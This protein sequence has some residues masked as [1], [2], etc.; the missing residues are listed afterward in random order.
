MRDPE[1]E[2]TL[3][4]S[5]DIVGHSRV[6]SPAVQSSRVAGINAVVRAFLEKAGGLAY[7]T[8]GGDG[9]HV[10]MPEHMLAQATELAFD[11]RR[12][13]VLN[14][15]PLRI[16]V[17]L[18][19]VSSIPGADGRVQPV[20]QG[21]NE[22]G[23]ILEAGSERGV[24]ASAEFRELAERQ[25]LE[26]RFHDARALNPKHKGEHVL[27]LMSSLDW[28]S[29][30]PA[31][32]DEEKRLQLSRSPSVWERLY[33]IKKLAQIDTGRPSVVSGLRS[34]R[35]ADFSLRET[36]PDADST[37]ANPFLGYL[38]PKSLR[39]VLRSAQLIERGYNE[40][41]CHLGDGGD[42]MF[43]ILH[44]Q[45][46]VYHRDLDGVD[47]VYDSPDFVLRQGQTVG[48][49]A[50]ALQRSRTAD[51]V[52][53]EQTALL[54]FSFDELISRMRRSGRSSQTLARVDE[55]ITERTL[56][57]VSTNVPFLVGKDRTGP[58]AQTSQPWEG[59]LED[60][61]SDCA[62][63]SVSGSD[64]P[65]RLNELAAASGQDSDGIW[66]LVTGTLQSASNEGKKVQGQSPSL[67]YVNIPGKILSPDHSYISQEGSAKLLRIGT[68]ALSA[69]PGETYS[70]VVNAVQ[71]S[72][73]PLYYYDVF[74][75][76]NYGDDEVAFQWVTALREAGLRV[77]M[78]SPQIGTAFVEKIEK[79]ILDSLVLIPFVSPHTMVK[80]GEANWVRKEIAFRE[81]NFY[82]PWIIPVSLPGADLDEFRLAYTMIDAREGR[83]RGVR[84]I[85]N[86]VRRLRGGEEVPP[87]LR[88][89]DLQRRMRAD[90]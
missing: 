39:D 78:D 13:A 38:D 71:R 54:G 42:T 84:D 83:E 1:Q 76:Y 57:Y 18:G 65:V 87:T 19:L 61:S 68:S 63:L 16:T 62:L 56:E 49:L 3:I 58:L 48:E 9:G 26:V 2:S 10:L 90:G 4:V 17:H 12:W 47:P 46:G 29:G 80:R 31:P 15:V 85:V 64:A 81:A 6:A 25:A 51:L 79:A 89:R 52:S 37:A 53:L 27:S 7:W 41:L 88:G 24:V 82:S 35:P 44:G 14:S 21:I 33:Y 28:P 32:V 36:S 5:C 74:V 75:A 50:F 23:A 45:I 59:L 20:G 22:A 67:L 34:I 30:W 66:V 11:F 77:F 60:M 40:V 8:S 43:I 70:T 86:L 72:V 69:L 73:A 55:F